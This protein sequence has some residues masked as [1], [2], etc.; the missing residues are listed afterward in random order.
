MV[1]KLLPL[2]LINV[3]TIKEALDCFCL[4]LILKTVNITRKHVICLLCGIQHQPSG[5]KSM[6]LGLRKTGKCV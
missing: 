6:A 4:P 3:K 2:R 1:S 5:L